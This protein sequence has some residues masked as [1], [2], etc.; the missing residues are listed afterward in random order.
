MLYYNNFLYSGDDYTITGSPL[1]LAFN[2]S[3]TSRNVV[4]NINDDNLL[5]AEEY[6]LVKLQVVSSAGVVIIMPSMAFVNITD[7]DRK[8]LLRQTV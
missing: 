2:S 8:C 6:F 3:Q 5:E 1:Y 4:I 7:N